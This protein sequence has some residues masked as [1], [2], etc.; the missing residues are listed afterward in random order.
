MCRYVLLWRW[1]R[2]TVTCTVATIEFSQPRRGA[3]S[4]ASE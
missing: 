4:A 1:M 2:S 3:G